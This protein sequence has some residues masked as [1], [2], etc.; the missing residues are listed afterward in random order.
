MIDH[1][2]RRESRET[3]LVCDTPRCRSELVFQ[4]GVGTQAIRRDAKAD[5]WRRAK[6]WVGDGD[7]VDYYY[8]DLCPKCAEKE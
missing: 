8:V 7:Y 4:Y 3:T 2:K 1:R 6:R 5:G